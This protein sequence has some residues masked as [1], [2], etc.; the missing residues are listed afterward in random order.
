MSSKA[1]F[2]S[3][4]AVILLAIYTGLVYV[5][6]FNAALL[7]DEMASAMVLIGGLVSAL[8]IAELGASEPGKPPA[9]RALAADAPDTTIKILTGIT[10]LYIAVWIACGLAALVYGWTRQGLSQSVVDLGKSWLG[11][12]VAS[13]YAYLGIKPQ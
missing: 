6:I 12:A 4:I 3:V 2:G 11:L 5:G 1:L 13:G 9:V 7:T 10:V 8:V